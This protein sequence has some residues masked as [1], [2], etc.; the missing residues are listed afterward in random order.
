[1]EDPNTFFLVR[2]TTLQKLWQEG[3]S[4]AKGRARPLKCV[5]CILTFFSGSVPFLGLV[6]GCTPPPPKKKTQ[7]T[8]N[9]NYFYM[10]VFSLIYVC[11]IFLQETQA[12]SPGRHQKAPGLLQSPGVAWAAPRHGRAPRG[13]GWPPGAG[14]Y[15]SRKHCEGFFF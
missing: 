7:K 11:F 5:F 15:F 9:N 6:L 10:C 13:S 12:D 3:S 1:M 4:R 2:I 8:G 14:G